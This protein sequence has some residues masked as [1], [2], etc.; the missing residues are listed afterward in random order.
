MN[1]LKPLFV[2]AVLVAV[3]YGVYV[4][5][6]RKSTTND[7]LEEAPRWPGNPTA[8]IPGPDLA[9]PT[10]PNGATTVSP[11]PVGTFPGGGPGLTPAP[12]ATMPGGA[13]PSYP[14]IGQPDPSSGPGSFGAMPPP[15]NSLDQPGSAY[16]DTLADWFSS[17]LQAVR[18]KIEEGSYAEAHLALS[19]LYDDQRLSP[20]QASQ[21]NDLLNKLAGTVIYSTQDLL[22][23]PHTVRPGDTLPQIAEQYGVPWQLLGKI[24]FI[25]DPANLVP[26]QQLKVVRGPFEA[27]IRLE[28]RELTLFLD[29]RFAG[30]FPIGIGV[31]VDRGNLEGTYIVCEKKEDPAYYGSTGTA[32]GGDPTNPY[33]RLWVGLGGQ[34]GEQ[35]RLGIHGTNDPLNLHGT[36]GRGAIRMANKD[37]EDVFGILSLGSHVEILR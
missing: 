16:P 9:T 23:Q 19:D 6:N 30:T 3:A 34:I 20:G 29:G 18:M 4:S 15:G 25:R 32:A 13:L 10:F 37:I 1:S 36:T 33:G 12:A 2:V 17:Y 22:E 11:A 7:S 24:N 31:D 27:R 28:R 5:I 14:T 26:G 8:Q 35:T 21:V